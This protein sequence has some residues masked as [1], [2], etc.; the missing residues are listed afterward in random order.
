[1]G[2]GVARR[3]QDR[4]CPVRVDAGERMPGRRGANRIDRDLGVAVGAVLEAD[5]HRQPGA[6]LTVDLA[7][8][9]PRAD[10]CPGDRVGDVLRGDRVEEL[11]ARGQ[12]EPE[13]L[14]Q[15]APGHPQAG[16]HVAGVVQVRVVDQALPAGGGAGLLEVDAHDDE[17]VVAQVVGPSGEALG[18]LT[19]GLDVMDAAGADD[20]EEPVVLAVEHGGGLP[21]PTQHHLDRSGRERQLR[22]QVRRAVERL[23]P[24][25]SPI[26]NSFNFGFHHNHH[27]CSSS[28]VFS[29]KSVGT[30]RVHGGVRR[31]TRVPRAGRRGLKRTPS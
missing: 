31:C 26:A 20:D 25:D 24:L 19:G 2:V 6:E 3:V 23:D 16:V 1:M 28:P 29:G 22:E 30:A 18:V 7:L 4:R 11:A 15:Q 12:P 8:R 13:H 9:R 21:A 5:R 10:R 17:E 27:P 14:E